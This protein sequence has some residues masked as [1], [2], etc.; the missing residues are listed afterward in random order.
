MPTT[1]NAPPRSL[2]NGGRCTPLCGKERTYSVY[3]FN[4]PFAPP[5]RRI[6]VRRPVPYQDCLQST[7][8]VRM[9][10]HLRIVYVLKV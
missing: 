3:P 9:G 4:A 5:V 1:L 8:H 2:W 10:G 6:H 7:L